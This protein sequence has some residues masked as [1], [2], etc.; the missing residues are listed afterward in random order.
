VQA[1]QRQYLGDLR[2]L[3]APGR[4]DRRGEPRPL[5]GVRVDAPVVD[6]R[7][8]HLD[9]PGRGEYL[10]GLVAAVAHHEPTTAGVA[11]VAELGDVGIHL[12]LQ[13]LG[14]HPSGTLPDDLIDQRRRAVPAAGVIGVGSS[15]NYR[16][17]GS[18]LSDQRCSAGLLESLKIT[19]RV[20]PLEVIHRFQ[21]LLRA[22]SCF[23]MRASRSRCRRL[24]AGLLLRHRGRG[25]AHPR[26]PVGRR[27]RAAR[28]PA[29]LREAQRELHRRCAVGGAIP[30]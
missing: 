27:V 3:T 9:R 15:R 26:S 16:E 12:G 5:A 19:G 20:R 30:R 13:G 28:G 24:G 4:Q 8:D 25:G 23:P 22:C 2:G 10:A 21:A 29:G 1:Q 6:P 17:H 14:Q 11:F 18:Y 7:G